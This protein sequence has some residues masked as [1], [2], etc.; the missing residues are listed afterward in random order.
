MKK[1]TAADLAAK[2]RVV[3][4]Y[5]CIVCGLKP[6]QIELVRACRTEQGMS[7]RAIALAVNGEFKIKVGEKAVLNHFRNHEATA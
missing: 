6:D 7:F 5:P 3:H 2:Y 1:P 4:K